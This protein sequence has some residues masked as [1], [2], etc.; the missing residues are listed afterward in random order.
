M[1]ESKLNFQTKEKSYIIL[2]EGQIL[3]R[4]K[5][6]ESPGS[7]HWS[8][9]V[10]L[11]INLVDPVRPQV[12]RSYAYS[13]MPNIYSCM[14]KATTCF[15]T[16]PVS[17]AGQTWP[18]LY[19]KTASTATSASILSALAPK[20][21]I[22]NS[23]HVDHGRYT[24]TKVR[25]LRQLTIE[26]NNKPAAFFWRITKCRSIIALQTYKLNFG[27]KARLF[28]TVLPLYPGGDRFWFLSLQCRA[29]RA[30]YCFAACFPK[31]LI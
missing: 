2:N 18:V 24:Y 31:T 8:W 1:L 29:S 13:S 12:C 17:T 30:V 23:Y 15:S 19:L 20:Q 25:F 9:P 28:I 14:F 11:W 26:N 7:F 21:R 4:S 6:E 3:L 5:R 16:R 22:F 27:K 10:H